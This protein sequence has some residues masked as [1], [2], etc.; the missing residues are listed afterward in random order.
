MERLNVPAVAK[1]AVSSL[2]NSLSDSSPS[3]RSASAEALYWF[4]YDEF[5]G[6]SL[7]EAAASKLIEMLEDVDNEDVSVRKEAARALGGIRANKPRAVPALIHALRD[8]EVEVRRE[9]AG[10]LPYFRKHKDSGLAVVAL[11][12]AL[13]DKEPAVR[14]EVA[15]ALGRFRSA[16]QSAV[17]A[18][19]TLLT[20]E[21]D[22]A[23][24][25]DV[26]EALKKIQ[27][28]SVG[29]QQR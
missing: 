3:V 5:G 9:A 18:L 29:D 4:D 23:V 1:S 26:I 24:R 21:R 19:K 8:S 22:E 16:A 2:T 17:L 28:E 25:K 6:E 11:T 20:T 27:G 14:N 13:T 10:A 7:Q 12:Q 15:D